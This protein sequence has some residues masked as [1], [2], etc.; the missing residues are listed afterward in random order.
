MQRKEDKKSRAWQLQADAEAAAKFDPTRLRQ[1]REDQLTEARALQLYQQRRETTHTPGPRRPDPYPHVFDSM[2]RIRQTSAFVAGSKI[3]LPETMRRDDCRDHEEIHIPAS[4]S[5]SRAKP[6]DF[7]GTKEEVC[8]RPPVLVSQLDE[9]GQIAFRNTKA[10]NR[11]QTVV[12]EEAYNSN[13]NLLICAPTG[14]G[15]TNIAMLTIVHQ[16]RQ[17]MVSGVLRKDDFKIVYIAPM[18]ALAAEMVANF[19][20][21]LAPLGVTVRELTGDITLTKQEIMQTQMLVATPE[22]WDVVTRKSL[23]DVSLSLLV[24]LLIIDEVH[25]LH[26]DRGAVI[27]TIV[28]RTLRQVE[29]SQKMIRIVGLSATLPNYLDVARFL[30]VNPARGLFFFD[31]RFRPVPLAQSFIGVKSLNKMKQMEQMEQATYDKAL[32]ML[33]QGHQVMVFVHARN[34]TVKT[35]MKL[36]DMA[37]NLGDIELFRPESDKSLGEAQRIMS[38]KLIVGVFMSKIRQGE[39]LSGIK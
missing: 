18:K 10:L 11:I 30:N 12:F 6:E 23:G 28:A 8:F 22:K 15:K 25:L 2:Q 39:T 33:R 31:S 26:D 29:S 21:R 9:I 4:E 1:M 32:E 17:N 27:E 36:R 5:L 37:K 35:A 34:A 24:R 3:L 7:K 13:D 38:S 20:S 16:I 14:A 19:S